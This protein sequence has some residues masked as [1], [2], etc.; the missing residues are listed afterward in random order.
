MPLRRTARHIERMDAVSAKH[1]GRARAAPSRLAY[2]V[3][4]RRIVQLVEAW[5]EGRQGTVARTLR[6]AA[7]ILS[8]IAYINEDDALV[9]YV[10]ERLHDRDRGYP[11]EK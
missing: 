6:V 10:L 11:I 1:L 2:H 7:L 5:L 3:D 8:G 9:P 4:F